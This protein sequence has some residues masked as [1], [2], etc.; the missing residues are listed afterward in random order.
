LAGASK[1][2]GVKKNGGPCSPPFL[3]FHQ[4]R[5]SNVK[6]DASSAPIT[7]G[8]ASSC[9]AWH[10]SPASAIVIAVVALAAFQRS[11]SCQRPSPYQRALAG[12]AKRPNQPRQHRHRMRLVISTS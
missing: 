2:T 8:S 5:E 10:R 3:P 6:I 11:S 12:P 4:L 1:V 9:T 7:G